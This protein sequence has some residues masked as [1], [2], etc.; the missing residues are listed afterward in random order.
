MK[1]LGF[2]LTKISA[3]KISSKLENVK[4]NTNIDISEISEAKADEMIKLK[5]DILTIKF[6]FILDY[7]DYAKIEF[8]GILILAIDS[9]DSKEILKNWKN[10]KK[11]SDE[12]RIS[13]FNLILRKSTLRA[14]Q[15][16]EE[17]GIPLHLPLPSLKYPDKKDNN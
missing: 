5:E 4:I 7:T 9:K 11:I 14:L 8:Q 16:E 15:L 13:L 3:E 17:I 1:I 6:T 12:F 10:D 2:N